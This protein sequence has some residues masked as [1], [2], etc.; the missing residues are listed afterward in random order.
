M[1][2]INQKN[3]IIEE[4]LHQDRPQFWYVPD[5]DGLECLDAAFHTHSYAPH[6]HETFAIGVV[7]RGIEAFNVNGVQHYAGPGNFCLINPE[8]L[9]DGKPHLAEG[10]HYHMIYPSVAF[11]KQLAEEIFEK[12]ITGSISFETPTVS[13]PELAQRFKTWHEGLRQKRPALEKDEALLGV[14]QQL[15]TSHG[16]FDAPPAIGSE[17]KVIARV[18]DYIDGHYAQDLTLDD[19]AQVSGFNRHYLIRVFKKATGV[20]PHKYLVDVRVR[21]VRTMLRSGM[22]LTDAALS[23]GFYDQS[24]MTHAFKSVVGITP[25]AYLA[26]LKA[27]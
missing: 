8:D 20:T 10:F 5:Y 16:R 19:L 15:L 18:R 24:H 17:I 21:A 23:A 2:F 1:D 25:G 9:H 13:D 14:M 7:S 6:R 26:A 3:S 4:R 27:G 12:P 11:I 22:G